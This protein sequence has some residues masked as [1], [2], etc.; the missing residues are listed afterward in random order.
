[1][2]KWIGAVAMLSLVLAG[3]AFAGATKDSY[4]VSAN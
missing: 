3:M 2:K 1:M 4:K